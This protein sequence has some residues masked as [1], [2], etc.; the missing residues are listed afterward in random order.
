[1]R[2]QKETDKVGN[3]TLKQKGRGGKG[4]KKLFT[5]GRGLESSKRHRKVPGQGPFRA[6]GLGGEGGGEQLF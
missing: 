2:G 6:R 4:E 3:C 1:M 5:R